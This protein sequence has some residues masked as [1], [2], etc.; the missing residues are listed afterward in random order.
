[1]NPEDVRHGRGRGKI[2][3]RCSL[4]ADHPLATMSPTR[5]VKQYGVAVVSIRQGRE[6]QSRPGATRA[7]ARTVPGFRRS[8]ELVAPR[9]SPV[10][11]QTRL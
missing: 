7:R 1:V 3:V 6:G 2:I 5:W 10:H 8:P 4:A 11:V 9:E